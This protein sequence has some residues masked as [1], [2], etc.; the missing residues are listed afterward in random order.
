MGHFT[1]FIQVKVHNEI[2]KKFWNSYTLQHFPKYCNVRLVFSRNFPPDFPFPLQNFLDPHLIYFTVLSKSYFHS[3]FFTL[4]NPT[5][6]L[7]WHKFSPSVSAGLDRFHRI[8]MVYFTKKYVKECR[9]PI[10]PT[11]GVGFQ[12]FS[13]VKASLIYIW[14]T[15]TCYI[16]IEKCFRNNKMYNVMFCLFDSRSRHTPLSTP[17][18][19][20]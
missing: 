9:C 12:K 18:R 4:C 14:L 20:R 13:I 10:L 11:T 3:L 5:L 2:Q 16:L 1:I 15:C 6:C 7:F 17:T 19:P 8:F